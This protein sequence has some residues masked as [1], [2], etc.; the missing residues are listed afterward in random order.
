MIFLLYWPRS[1][2]QGST[3]GML[4]G[5]SAHFA[6]YVMGA[7]Y[8]DSFFRPYR[9]LDFDP[10]IIGLV[11]SFTVTYFTTLA[12]PAPPQ[13]LVRKYFYRRVESGSS[14]LAAIVERDA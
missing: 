7:F 11:V 12:T 1:N 9:L 5:F 14:N 13:E 3:I 2:V 10:I 4:A 6:M 8:N